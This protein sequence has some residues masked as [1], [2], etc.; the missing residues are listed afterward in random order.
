MKKYQE[1]R[2]KAQSGHHE[3]DQ[4]LEVHWTAKDVQ[5]MAKEIYDGTIAD[6]HLSLLG[7]W[8]RTCSG[9]YD[10]AREYIRELGLDQVCQIHGIR[11]H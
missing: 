2:Q 5:H 11:S 10:V 4:S 3:R 6:V 1:G 8:I 9:N 7:Y